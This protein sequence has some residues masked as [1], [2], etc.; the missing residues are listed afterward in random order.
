MGRRRKASNSSIKFFRKVGF[1]KP[2]FSSNKSRGDVSVIAVERGILEKNIIESFRRVITRR[3]KRLGKINIP[4]TFNI[5]ISAKPKGMRMGK[6]KG[7]ISKYVARVGSGTV[8]L[9]IHTFNM[10]IAAEALSKSLY[11]LPLKTEIRLRN[12]FFN[13]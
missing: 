3:L 2:F 12:S 10:P 7:K 5:P 13:D 1:N 6:G 9:D 8:L 4:L 11:K